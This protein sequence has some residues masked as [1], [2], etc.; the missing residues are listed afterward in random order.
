MVSSLTGAADAPFFSSDDG[1]AEGTIQRFRIPA[2]RAFGLPSM[3]L[4]VEQN[5]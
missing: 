5:K 3:Y 1:G 2:I 4:N